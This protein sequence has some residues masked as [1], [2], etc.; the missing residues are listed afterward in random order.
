MRIKHLVFATVVALALNNA[1]EAQNEIGVGTPGGTTRSDSY[2]WGAGFGFYTPA[3]TGS[4]IN[5]L[6]F[7]DPTGTGLASSHTVDLYGYNGNN[8]SLLAS[9][10]VQAGTVDPLID[11]YRWASISTLSLPDIGQ[12]ADY[13]IILASQGGGDNWTDW[14]SGLSMNPAIGT[15]TGNGA[16]IASNSGQNLGDSPANLGV[17]GNQGAANPY[18]GANLAFLEPVPEPATF[19]L[20]GAG[21]AM[22]MTLCRNKKQ[23]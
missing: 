5:A 4:T 23:P 12:G 16:L 11:G 8:Y 1:V 2:P 21:V 13:Y 10:T 6:G 9:A 18:G 17:G 20:V 15:V 22:L 14:T 7:W 19:A 3:G